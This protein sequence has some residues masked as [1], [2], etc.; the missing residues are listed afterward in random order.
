MSDNAIGKWRAEWADGH[1]Q[2]VN[3][4]PHPDGEFIARTKESF[5][6]GRTA[7]AAVA[8]FFDHDPPDAIHAPDESSEA[9]TAAF[10]RGVEAMRAACLAECVHANGR[11]RH[12]E[13]DAL[14]ERL[15][16]LIGAHPY[17]AACELI[18]TLVR[19]IVV[20]PKETT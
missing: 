11:M 13:I 9:E 18:E 20:D 19:A 6:I 7:R 8:S 15:R 4:E 17:T 16:Y 3:V 10:H 5:A 1:S 12:A 2:T 14:D